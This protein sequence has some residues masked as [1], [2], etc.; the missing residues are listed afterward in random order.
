MSWTP[1]DVMMVLTLFLAILCA[2]AVCFGFLV[3]LMSWIQ[4]RPPWRPRARPLVGIDIIDSSTPKGS[5][6]IPHLDDPHGERKS[7]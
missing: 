2:A 3:L 4:P 5:D 6:F 1:Y 7:A